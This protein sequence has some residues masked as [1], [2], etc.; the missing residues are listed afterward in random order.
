MVK[1]MFSNIC[2]DTMGLA[3]P[4]GTHGYGDASTAGDIKKRLMCLCTARPHSRFSSWNTCHTVLRDIVE[5]SRRVLFSL[6]LI[7]ETLSSR[8]EN[9]SIVEHSHEKED[10]SC[11]RLY[12]SVFPVLSLL[13]I[14]PIR[15]L[16]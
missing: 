9:C 10:R 14:R 15:D 6:P 13:Y 2:V 4:A 5:N 8:C 11:P 16:R 7:L 1:S 3:F 12:R